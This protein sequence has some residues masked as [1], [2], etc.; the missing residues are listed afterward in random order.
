MHILRETSFD[1]V[2]VSKTT[3]LTLWPFEIYEGHGFPN[4]KSMFF[5][6]PNTDLPKI[7]FL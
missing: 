2:R 3:Y 1:G 5:V 7:D 6:T 4:M